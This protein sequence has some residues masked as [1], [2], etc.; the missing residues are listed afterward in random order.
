MIE[1]QFIHDSK[2]DLERNHVSTADCWCEPIRERWNPLSQ[3]WETWDRDGGFWSIRKGEVPPGAVVP[4]VAEMRPQA[5]ITAEAE[6]A[7]REAMRTEDAF[8]NRVD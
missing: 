4:I 2:G 3:V 6:Q 1:D 5:T 8:W 7:E